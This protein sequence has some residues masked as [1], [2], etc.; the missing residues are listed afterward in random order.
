MPQEEERFLSEFA[1]AV[2]AV[3]RHIIATEPQPYDD[4]GLEIIEF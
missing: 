3:A 4:K 1:F 2:L